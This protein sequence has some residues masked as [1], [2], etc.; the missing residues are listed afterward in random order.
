QVCLAGSRLYVQRG[1]YDEFVD[2]F[3]DAA[4]ALVI[5]N[6]REE[7]TQLGPLASA[8]HYKKVRGYVEEVQSGAGRMA[9]GG[10]GEGWVVRPTV[11]LDAPL[12]SRVVCEEVFGPVVTV[13]PF[14]TE[15]DAVALA[16][17]TP[18]GLNAMVFT[19]NL[20]RAHRMSA[21]LK[22]GTVWVNCFFIRA[23]GRRH[24]GLSGP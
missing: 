23:Q 24:A 1:I 6:P 17:D 15:G 8:E 4:E 16:N 14:D 19:E 10:F 13:H 11:V 7:T 9:T 22:A 3:V 5:G 2:R 21:R 12:D 18:Y 20:S